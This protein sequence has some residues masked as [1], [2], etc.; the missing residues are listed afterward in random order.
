MEKETQRSLETVAP[1][2]CGGEEQI[3]TAGTL[4]G[5]VRGEQ[6][7]QQQGAAGPRAALTL[8]LLSAPPLLP[9][10]LPAGACLVGPECISLLELQHTWENTPGG[11]G[12]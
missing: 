6:S 11:S 8:R 7:P 3:P 1:K 10:L 9:L 12:Y 2:I 5:P 4:Q